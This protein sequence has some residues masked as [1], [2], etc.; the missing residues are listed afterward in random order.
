[1]CG[2]QQTNRRYHAP[3][4][5]QCQRGQMTDQRRISA[6]TF[7]LFNERNRI[8][9]AVMSKLFENLRNRRRILSAPS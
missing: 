6:L 1:V 8:G 4:P 7:Y 5:R 3:H 2:L 9:G